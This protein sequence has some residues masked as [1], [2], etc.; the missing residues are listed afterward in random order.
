MKKNVISTLGTPDLIFTPFLNVGVTDAKWFALSPMAKNVYGFT[1]V[2]VESASDAG[3][4]HGVNERAL[5][6]EY[7]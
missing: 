1:A 5:I 7:A 4:W 6:S 3:R 2:R